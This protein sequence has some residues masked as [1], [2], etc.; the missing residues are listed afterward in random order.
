LRRWVWVM[1][2]LLMLWPLPVLADPQPPNV[3]TPEAITAPEPANT[4]SNSNGVGSIIQQIVKATVFFPANTFREAIEKAARALF[5][6]ELNKLRQ[7]FVDL[8]QTVQFGGAA[9]FGSA[10]LPPPV[11]RL[12]E[13]MTQAAVP[14]WALSLGMMGIAVMTRNAVGLGYGSNDAPNELLH[15]GFITLA[16]GN[17]I[18]LVNLAHAGFGALTGAVLALGGGGAAQMVDALLPRILLAPTI[19]LLVLIPAMLIAFVTMLAMTAAYVARHVLL[20]TVA[21]LAPLAIATEGIPFLRFVF[22]DWLNLFIRLELLSVI[23]AFILVLLANLSLFT[24][25]RGGI[26]GALISLAIMVGLASAIIGLNWSVFQQ[27]FGTAMS[28]AEQTKS[29]LSQVMSIVA[30]GVGAAATGGAAGGVGANEIA[31]AGASTS[32]PVS[33]MSGATQSSLPNM[34]SEIG[35]ATGSNTLRGLGKGLQM[36][37][38]AQQQASVESRRVAYSQQREDEQLGR[39]A[40]ADH[41]DE[42]RSFNQARQNIQTTYGAPAAQ[43]ANTAAAPLLRAMSREAKSATAAAKQAGYFDFGQ[44][45]GAVMEEMAVQHGGQPSQN[46]YGAAPSQAWTQSPPHTP[47]DAGLQPYDFGT[48]LRM[49]TALQQPPAAVPLYANRAFEARISPAGHDLVARMGHSAE[50]IG[51]Q[52]GS[53]YPNPAEAEKAFLA[54]FDP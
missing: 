37:Q 5:Q 45:A 4:G 34:L 29:A 21:G 39:A 28:A 25:G 13:L 22:R 42:L 12:G 51:Q 48:G 38:R 49:A 20:L 36:G 16:S 50:A 30:M 3:P 24:A 18:V 8:L 23:N 10:A 46:T 32:G 14:L 19:P 52:I 15:W 54:Q 1:I 26:G 9:L 33:A 11:Q 7:P 44:L 43:A 6:A 31:A 2:L 35:Q 27:V 53:T 17:G 41:A 47:K 40:G